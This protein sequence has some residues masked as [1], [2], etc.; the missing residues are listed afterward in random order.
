M[1]PD[2][3]ARVT[4]L[5]ETALELDPSRRASFLDNACG[6]D[7][8]TRAEVE[9]LLAFQKRAQGF[10][11]RP[12]YE[13]AA[14]T[15]LDDA[16][17]LRAGQIVGDYHILSLIGEGGMGEVYLAEDRTLGRNVAI[18]L[19]KA[20]FESGRIVRHFRNEERIL[21][22]LNH[23]NIARLYGGGLM[24][25]DTPYFV[26][27]YVDGERID[28]YCRN[29]QL[30]VL[31]RLELFR[32]VCAAVAYAH[33]RLVIHRDLK[34]AN[35][36]VTSEGEPKLLDFGIAKLLD[37]QT[38]AMMEQTITMQAVMTPDYASPEQ[39]RGESMTTASDVYSLGVVLYELLTGERPY[40]IKTRRPDEIARAITEK[41]PARPSTAVTKS[42][43]SNIEHRT[44]KL[45]RGDLDNIV[46]KAL[47]KEPERRYASATQL[48]DDIRRHL[49]GLPVIARKDTLTYRASKFVARNRV[50]VSAAAFVMLSIL[51]GLIIAVWQANKAREQ[52]DVAQRERVKA[53]RI[54]QFLQRM[55][56]FSNQSM[57]TLSPI[58]Q[59]KDVTVNE[60]LD[61]ITPQVETELAD[62]PEVRAQILR[63]IGSAYASQGRFDLAEKNLRTAFET[64]QQLYG[65]QHGETVAT[66]M[67]LAGLASQKLK[68]DQAA[69]LLKKCVGFYREQE[70][71]QSADFKPFNLA[72]ALDL[73]A[74][75]TLYRGEA[76]TARALYKEALQLAEQAHLQG[77]ERSLLAGVQR[78]LGGVLVRAGELKRG[79]ELLRQ[80]L[81][82]DRNI[83]QKPRWERG[84]TLTLL[85]ELL[86]Q[87]NEPAEAEKYFSEGEEVYR[88][89]LGGENLYLAYNL[90]QQAVALSYMKNYD[91]AEAKARESVTMSEKV[92]G[93]DLGAG[94]GKGTWGVILTTLGRAKEGE[95]QLRRAIEII[96]NQ[97]PKNPVLLVEVKVGLSQCL[98]AQN[99]LAEAEVVAL[100]A[101]NDARQNFAK[102]NPIRKSATNILIQIYEKQGK[103]AVDQSVNSP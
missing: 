73:L 65:E 39:V 56:S 40:R 42:K 63:T 14:E 7:S 43:T 87:K 102:D 1:Q 17:K 32:R 78:D 8:E 52:R 59:K 11:E 91:R 79:E 92:L 34:P 20:G 12:A 72:E 97:S 70:R 83:F 31:Q 46:L 15:L 24:S 67:Q 101:C 28:D 55:L 60:M 9:S 21:A 86:S 3:T 45:L 54:N 94:A 30:S 88:A 57:S 26:M 80:S 93:N 98:L 33:Q 35:I 51:A 5:V 6:N 37:P 48:S 23:P 36:R 16:G 103:H 69:D 76:A 25:Q 77:T 38:V 81:A 41:E 62:Q 66:M 71:V 90:Y 64:Q 85:G 27:E 2:V 18:K 84:A 75:V 44:S 4:E 99:R 61:Q 74:T 68:F 53:E 100:E 82:L 19:V 96:K 13:Q 10:I 89:T 22:G 58:A 47:R 29:K 49:E 50:A 95:A